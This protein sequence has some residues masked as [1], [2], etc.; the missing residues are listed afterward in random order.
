MDKA[1]QA[2]QSHKTA[3]PL[4]VIPQEGVVQKD[5]PAVVTRLNRLS[6]DKLMNLVLKRPDEEQKIL[7]EQAE[8]TVRPGLYNVDG[9][10]Y[11]VCPKTLYNEDCIVGML[12]ADIALKT[13]AIVS[14]IDY[15]EIVYTKAYDE[16]F[17]M[18]LWNGCYTTTNLQRRRSKQSYELGRTVMFSLIVKWYFANEEKLGIEALAKD[19]FFFGNNPEEK[20]GK[21]KTRFFIK[22]ALPSFFEDSQVGNLLLAIVNYGAQNMSFALTDSELKQVIRENII[23]VSSL[24]ASCYPTVT[25]RRGKKETSTNRRPNPIRSSPLFFKEEMRLVSPISSYIFDDLEGWQTTFLDSVLQFGYSDYAQSIKAKI[26]ARWETLQRFAHVTK[27]RLQEIRRMTKESTLKKAQVSTEHLKTFLRGSKDAANK[28]VSEIHHIIGAASLRLAVSY[29][30]KKTFASD[31]DAE[32]FLFIMAVKTYDGLGYYETNTKPAEP[33][34][35]R[36]PFDFDFKNAVLRIKKFESCSSNVTKI[37]SLLTANKRVNLPKKLEELTGSAQNLLT[38]LETVKGTEILDL[39]SACSLIYGTKFTSAKMAINS[40]FGNAQ[41][42][43]KTYVNKLTIEAK[44]ESNPE[45]R[46]VLEKAT[47]I[48]SEAYKSMPPKAI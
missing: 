28:L 35:T 37:V 10:T 22:N 31:I 25:I 15:P 24:I 47:Q 23:D 30:F 32:R 36:D 17:I 21:E 13:K 5:S 42:S 27:I 40:I 20:T 4:R 43:L 33:K 14:L 3:Q 11:F 48:L 29:A 45:Y 7:I 16:K 18:G 12:I 34:L 6:L 38:A 26:R 9:Q 2:A 19:Q 39:D 41:Q 44:T 1:A 46:K 8:K